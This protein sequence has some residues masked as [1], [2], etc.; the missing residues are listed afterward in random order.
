MVKAV[1]FDFYNTLARFWPPVE[2]IQ[3]EACAAFGLKVS[4]AGVRRGYA[5]A[6]D[7]MA[8]ENAV[9][10]IFARSPEERDA[11]FAQ[12]ELL[13]LEGA[14]LRVPLE[15]ARRVWRRTQEVPKDLA[16]F[17]DALPALKRLKQR[18][19]TVAVVSNLRR[20]MDALF[21]RLGLS[22]YLDFIVSSEETGAEKPD[23]AIFQAALERAAV[24]PREAM[25]VGDQYHSDVVG[26]QGVGMQAV[27]VD[28]YGVQPQY[29]GCVKVRR[30]TELV[31]LVDAVAVGSGGEGVP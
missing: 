22:P 12:Y 3:Q 14:G 7:F 30:L 13:V 16:L 24:E 8:R 20:D 27:L 19:L 15:M 2:Q 25:H 4:R 5:Q 18:G 21:N 26:A 23:P 1:F 9:R 17:P 28:R 6:D 29:P 10:P 31:H 11:F